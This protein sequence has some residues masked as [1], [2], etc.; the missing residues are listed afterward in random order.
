MNAITH[1]DGADVVVIDVRGRK[2]PAVGE[3]RVE[4]DRAVVAVREAARPWLR[5]ILRTSAPDATLACA[6]FSRDGRE[7]WRGPVRLAFA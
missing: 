7:Y 1:L 4:A 6:I 5:S 2:V 3:V